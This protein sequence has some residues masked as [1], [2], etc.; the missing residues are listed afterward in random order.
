VWFSRVGK[1]QV[2]NFYNLDPLPQG[3]K[4]L[5]VWGIDVLTCQDVIQ[6]GIIPVINLE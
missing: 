2:L 1:N 4:Y 3:K 5:P 6:E